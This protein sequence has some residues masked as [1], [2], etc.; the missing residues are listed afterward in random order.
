MHRGPLV[1]WHPH[2]CNFGAFLAS[3][4]NIN[5]TQ[6][7]LALDHVL[8][9][10]LDESVTISICQKSAQLPKITHIYVKKTNVPLLLTFSCFGNVFS[11]DV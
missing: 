5:L 8:L 6:P 3:F 10:I 7:G 4:A 2:R 1:G 11:Q 9:I